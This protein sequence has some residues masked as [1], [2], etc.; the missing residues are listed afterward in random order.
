MENLRSVQG[1]KAAGYFLL[2]FGHA[3]I[4]FGLVI[5]KRN[6]R[7]F[8]ESQVFRFEVYQPLQQVSRVRSFLASARAG[9]VRFVGEPDIPLWRRLTVV[10][11]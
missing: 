9:V 7:V 10:G 11:R 3:N 5:R 2:H 4:V 8:H 6:Q 1:S